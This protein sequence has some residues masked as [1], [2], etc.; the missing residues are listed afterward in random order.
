MGPLLFLIYIN[1]ISIIN[2]VIGISLF[3]DETAIV[4]SGKTPM[5]IKYFS[6]D[7]QSINDWSN[8]NKLSINT[9]KSKLMAFGKEILDS[10]ISITGQTMENMD[11]FKYLD[12]EVDKKLNFNNQ[13]KK[14]CTKVSKF[15]GVLYRGRSCFSKQSLP[16]FYMTYVILIISYGLIAYGYTSK[17]NLDK[18]FLIQKKII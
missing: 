6:K 16:K 9:D 1:D 8:V 11:S 13:A 7:V 10:K 18:N 12:I 3:A 4:G 2:E 15:N 17:K 5:F 14:I